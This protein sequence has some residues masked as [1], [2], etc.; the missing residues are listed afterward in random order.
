VH[1]EGEATAYTLPERLVLLMHLLTG[2]WG[3]PERPVTV[4]LLQNATRDM[5]LDG[6]KMAH[7]PKLLEQIYNVRRY[8]ERYLDGGLGG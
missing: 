1:L 2:L 7:V 5:P 3:H 8:E 6:E 4:D